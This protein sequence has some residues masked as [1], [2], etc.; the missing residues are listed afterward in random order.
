MTEMV[1]SQQVIRKILINGEWVTPQSQKQ[2]KI[3]NPSNLDHLGTIADCNAADVDQAVRS[4]KQ[5]QISWWRTP[6]IE[7][8]NL[9]REVARRIRAISAE[10]AHTLCLETGKPLV[11]ATDCIAWV[12][13]AFDYYGEV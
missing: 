7:K 4:A 13:A 2:R 3:I 11:E 12:A 5:A 10:A 6:G 8:A 9:L 1:M